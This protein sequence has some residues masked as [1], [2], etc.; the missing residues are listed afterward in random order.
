MSVGTVEPLLAQHAPVQRLTSLCRDIP[1]VVREHRFARVATQL[2]GELRV[3]EQLQNAVCKR[4]N[5]AILNGPAG[6]AGEL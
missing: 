1:R 2:V 5:V 3:V 4:V 6:L